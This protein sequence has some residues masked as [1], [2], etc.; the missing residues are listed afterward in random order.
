MTEDLLEIAD[1]LY[2][3]PLSEFIA[4]RDAKVKELR[5]T[6]LAKRVKALAKPSLAGWVLNL[7][8]RQDTEQ[9]EQVLE[10]GA[11]LRE[12]QARMSGEQLRELTRQRRQVTA[13]VTT[14]ARKLAREHGQRVTDSVAEQVEATLTAAMLDEQCGRALRSGMLLAGFRAT[15]IDE[16]DLGWAVALPEALGFEARAREDVPQRPELHL[17]PD[18]DR[19]EKELAAAREALREAAEAL[20]EANDARAE[21]TS[22]VEAL[23]ARSMQIQAEIDELRRRI[24]ELEESADEVDE[25]LAEAEEAEQEAVLAVEEATRARDAAAD[26]VARLERRSPKR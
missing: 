9:V 13:A 20:V 8:V 24:A 1:E 22:E 19:D 15:G 6:D 18:P 23:Q 25:E 2:A 16:V 10:V 11:A 3:L 21:S 5:G 12:A 26:A 14:R 17:V 7:L 4:A